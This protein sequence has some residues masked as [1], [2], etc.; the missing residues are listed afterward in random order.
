MDALKM[1]HG[2]PVAK[3]RGGTNHGFSQ[4]H[5]YFVKREKNDSYEQCYYTT[6]CRR[7]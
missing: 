4:L 3:A 2:P 1:I 6:R 7:R 5:V